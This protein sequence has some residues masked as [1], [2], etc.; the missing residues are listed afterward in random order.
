[1]TTSYAP[2]L[3]RVELPLREAEAPVRVS[4]TTC[5]TESTRGSSECV[6]SCGSSSA[7]V[8]SR[9]DRLA[10]AHDV[11]I[12]RSEVD[13]ALAVGSRDVRIARCSTR[14]GPS[15]RGPASR[16]EPRGSRAGSGA[17]A[18]RSVLGTPSPVMLRQMG[19]SS[20]ASACI[21]S[22]ASP[23]TGATEVTASPRRHEVRIRRVA[24]VD[25][26]DRLGPLDSEGRVVP[27]HAAC[28]LGD[29]GLRD[30]VRDLGRRPQVSGTRARSPSERTARAGS[31]P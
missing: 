2:S 10:V 31:R 19:K 17:R 24:I 20:A 11:E 29:V 4:S 12:R 8:I 7:S 25:H 26:D 14:R 15:S 6:C 23:A 16:S 9:S 18:A 27:A 21:R 13:E 3:E 30:L 1:M 22:P 28:R 5:G